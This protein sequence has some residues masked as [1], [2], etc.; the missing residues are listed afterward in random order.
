[1]RRLIVLASLFLLTLLSSGCFFP[2]FKVTQE[3]DSL[4]TVHINDRTIMQFRK[5]P[6]RDF[7]M[8]TTEVSLAQMKAWGDSRSDAYY[9]RLP[10]YQKT[11]PAMNITVA[12][13]SS[14][15]FWMSRHLEH[16]LIPKGYFVRLP[17]VEEWE[18]VARCGTDRLYPWGNDWPPVKFEDG[19]YPNVMGADRF[20]TGTVATYYLG[21]PHAEFAQILGYRDGFPGPCPVELAG[22]NEWG[23]MGLA[24]NIEEWC[25]DRNQRKYVLKGGDWM[26]FHPDHFNISKF[27][28]MGNAPWPF[29][30]LFLD[31]RSHRG[32]GFRVV[33][34][35]K[36]KRD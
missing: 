6:G 14:F 15:C 17:T 7:W 35:P 13:A 23:I 36:R 30:P 3:A 22:K 10:G 9:A 16:G 29:C 27:D 1:M 26:S 20:T 12:E 5:I 31:R 21:K 8:G 19:R 28:E 18:Y 2:R 33:I 25:W 4:L 34:V 11:W 24:G 32:S